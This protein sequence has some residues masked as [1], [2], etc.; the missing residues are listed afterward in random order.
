[1]E[2]VHEHMFYL[3]M[4]GNWNYY[5]IYNLPV[6]IRA[7]FVQR[8]SKHFEEKNKELEKVQRASKSKSG[9]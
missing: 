1:M 2:M 3:I 4:H 8:L 7:W 6:K 9:R 5:D